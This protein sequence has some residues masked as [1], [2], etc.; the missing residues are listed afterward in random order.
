MKR[1]L[2]PPAAFMLFVLN[3][4]TLA[5]PD[6]SELGSR[7]FTINPGRLLQGFPI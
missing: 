3:L 4:N 5:V 1:M 6:V 7:S 2:I